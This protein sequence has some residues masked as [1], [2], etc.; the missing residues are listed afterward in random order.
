MNE[1]Q[2]SM[3]EVSLSE[4]HSHH[5]S[6]D[7]EEALKWAA[8]EKLPTYDRIRTSIL[9]YALEHDQQSDGKMVVLKEVDVRKLGMDERQKLIDSMFKVAEEDNE[10]YLRK[11]RERI[12]RVGIQLPNVEVRFEHLTVEADCYVGTR[13]LPTLPNVARNISESALGLLGIHW[14]KRQ[15][16]KILKDVSG[17]IKPSRMALLLGPPSS[18]KTTLLLALAAKLDSSLK[19]GGEITYNGYKLNEF[20][21]Q[22]TSAYVSQN[23]VHVGEMTVRET[24]EFSARC[25]GVGIQHELLSELVRREK[26]AGIYPDAELDLFMKATAVEG[27][28]SSLFVDYILKIL[29]LDICKDIIVGD[30]MKRGI[31]GGQRKRV[32][33]GEIIV[34]PSKALFMDEISTGLDSSTTFQIVKC[35]QQIAHFNGTTILMSLLQ[36]S[37]ET[38]D[39]FDDVILI[40]EG[41]IVYQGPRDYILEF[42]ETCGFKCP[43]RKGIADFLQEVTSRKDQEQYW[44]DRSKP[45]RYIGVEE[46]SIRFKQFHV[47]LQLQNELLIPFEKAPIHKEALVFKKYSVPQMELLK[48]NFYKEWLLIKRNSFVYVF[49]TVQIIVVAFVGAT[50]FIRTNMHLRNEEDGAIYVGAL[51]FSMVVNTF[52]SYG[53]VPFIISRLPVF[54]KHRDLL[55]HPAWTFTLP[56]VLLRIPI[57][58]F[59]SFVWMIV[60]YYTIGFAPEASRFFKQLLLI[61]LLYQMANAMFRF[62]AAVCRT[63]SISSTIGSF[64]LLLVFLLGGFIVPRGRIPIWWGWGYWISPLTYAFNGMAVNEMFA[65]RWMSKL[66]SDNTTRLGVAVLGNFDVFPERTWYWIGVAGLLGFAILFNLLFTL[67]LMYLNPIGKAQVTISDEAANEMNTEIES[68]SLN[69][70]NSLS[71]SDKVNKGEIAIVQMSSQLARNELNEVAEPAPESFH[72]VTPKRGMILSFVPLAL[73]F[74]SVNYYVDMPTIF[75]D[76]SIPGVPNIDEKYNP[77][78]WVLDVT[79]VA[80]EVRLGID[81]AEKYKS[82]SLYQDDSTDL[83]MIIGAMYSAVMFIGICNCA[84][85]LPVLSIERTVF[86]RESAAGMYSSLPYALSWRIPIWWSWYYWICPVA[87]TIYG[88]TISQYG[89]VEDTIEVPGMVPD[90]TIKWYIKHQFGYDSNFTGPVAVVLV[91]FT[92]FF[93]LMFA[94]CIRALNF[95]TR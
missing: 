78:T 83:H 71:S 45:Y 46:F 11:L 22:K 42:F 65:P 88:L 95:Q 89:D 30:D 87:W 5:Q 41:H 63:N 16:L 75:V 47:G 93:A 40:S 23:D 57:S 80:C 14:T 81:F 50:V 15:T 85:V 68:G 35:L 4:N 58:M 2:R 59:I 33:T 86:Y 6:N 3:V 64:T 21:P 25:L 20:V 76:E 37:P 51:V 54:Y 44:E 26:N 69:L 27:S 12:D 1:I 32:T 52:N 8:I 91:G 18:G 29:G 39:L 90:P 94:H 7:D 49:T 9:K 31:S 53:E 48:A 10:R 67:A 60:A 77:A 34:G 70:R 62:I 17:I 92:V 28:S 55:L 66:A 72:V 56:N 73:S 74:D 43:E 38:F 82:S 13:A 61:F 24:L 79:S 19:V 84:S 36:P